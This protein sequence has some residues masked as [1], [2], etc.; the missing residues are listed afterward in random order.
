MFWESRI[1]KEITPF[2]SCSKLLDP[3]EFFGHGPI[4]W[5]KVFKMEVFLLC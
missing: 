5:K 3:S 4:T 1:F 2:F